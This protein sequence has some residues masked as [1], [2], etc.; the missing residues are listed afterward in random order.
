MDKLYK[1]DNIL[2]NCRDVPSENQEHVQNIINILILVSWLRRLKIGLTRCQYNVICVVRSRHVTVSV[3][4]VA[5]MYTV[6]AL[7]KDRSQTL[8]YTFYIAKT[9]KE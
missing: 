4:T 6:L 3:C 7:T 8:G 1:K 5:N 2:S 9:A